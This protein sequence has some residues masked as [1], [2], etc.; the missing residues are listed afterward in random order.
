MSDIEGYCRT[1]RLLLPDL[2]DDDVTEENPVRFI[3]A[4]VESLDLER[5]G[6]ARTQAALTG[7]PADDPRDLLKLYL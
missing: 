2:L 7:R 4:S 5:L 1:E 6:L 3:D